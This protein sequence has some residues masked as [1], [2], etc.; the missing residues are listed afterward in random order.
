MSRVGKISNF[1]PISRRIS[2]TVQDRTKVTINDYYEVAYKIQQPSITLNGRYALYCTKHASFGVHQENL[3]EGRPIRSAQKCSRMTVVPGEVR[4]MRMF[5][6]VSWGG[7]QTTVWLLTTAVFSVL[8]GYFFVNLEKR[9]TLL[10]T[11]SIVGVS[12]I[13]KCMTLIDLECLISR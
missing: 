10:Y 12:L 8:V 7:R 4:F 1:Q 2:E 13:P 3:N 6:G 5:A 9:P 11:Q